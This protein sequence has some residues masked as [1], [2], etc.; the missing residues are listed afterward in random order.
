MKI[1]MNFAIYK[2]IM[3]QQEEKKIKINPT[4]KD[5]LSHHIFK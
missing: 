2:I 1:R 5:I 3:Q 4:I